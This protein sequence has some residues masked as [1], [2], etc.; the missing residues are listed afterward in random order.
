MA[1]VRDNH[2]VVVVD[3]ET[4]LCFPRAGNPASQGC[5]IPCGEKPFNTIWRE[6]RR[7]QL[8]SML[9]NITL[10]AC[11]R[12]NVWHGNILGVKSKD[13]ENSGSPCGLGP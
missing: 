4:T 5:E 8:I 10:C 12:S 11:A 3:L 1:Y 6:F 2:Y 7:E 9:M 13:Q